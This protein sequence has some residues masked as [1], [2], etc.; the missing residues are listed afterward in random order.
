MELNTYQFLD[1]TMFGYEQKQATDLKNLCTWMGL[2]KPIMISSEEP[3][4]T[5]IYKKE[6]FSGKKIFVISVKKL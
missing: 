5:H 4:V 6:R 3:D 1:G 2:I